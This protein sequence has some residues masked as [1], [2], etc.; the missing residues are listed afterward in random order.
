MHRQTTKHIRHTKGTH[1]SGGLVIILLAGVGSHENSTLL[2]PVGCEFTRKVHLQTTPQASRNAPVSCDVAAAGG[3]IFCACARAFTMHLHCS[4]SL[5][6]SS[7]SRYCEYEIED[8]VITATNW[9][10]HHI[11]Y[12]STRSCTS[13]K[14]PN[15]PSRP[16]IIT[17]EFSDQGL[18]RSEQLTLGYK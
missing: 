16:E 17:R 5:L 7:Y 1:F 13:W 11:N 15:Y 18:S 2:F 9:H 14:F 10:C 6:L 3:R 4:T 12:C 8:Q